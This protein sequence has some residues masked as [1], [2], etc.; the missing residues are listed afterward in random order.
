[1]NIKEVDVCMS[2]IFSDYGICCNLKDP[3]GDGYWSH[4]DTTYY[5]YV[6]NEHDYHLRTYACHSNEE[7]K[8]RRKSKIADD[9]EIGITYGYKP[10]YKKTLYVNMNN[11]GINMLCLQN[12]KINDEFM[13]DYVMDRCCKFD[14]LY[15]IPTEPIRYCDLYDY[16]FEDGEEIAKEIMNDRIV[17]FCKKIASVIVS[18]EEKKRN[19]ININREVIEWTWKPENMDKWKSW[20]L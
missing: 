2:D 14:D 12:D 13:E 10:S 9:F 3:D 8:M 11:F 18:I 5:L 1:M 16:V 17:E 20:R 15:N 6:E 19:M 7:M 4:R